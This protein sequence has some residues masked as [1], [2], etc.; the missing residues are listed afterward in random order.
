MLSN[1]GWWMVRAG[2]QA[3]RQGPCTA[4]VPPASC[5]SPPRTCRRSRTLTR[6]CAQPG[7]AIA[8]HLR[9]YH[10]RTLRRSGGA[11]ANLRGEK[12]D[13]RACRVVCRRWCERLTHEWFLHWR[14]NRKLLPQHEQRSLLRQLA[15]DSRPSATAILAAAR[16]SVLIEKESFASKPRTHR[17]YLPARGEIEVERHATGWEVRQRLQ[18]I[19]CC[20]S[21]LYTMDEEGYDEDGC[22]NVDHCKLLNA[23]G[24]ETPSAAASNGSRTRTGR[25]LGVAV[26]SA[27]RPGL[28]TNRMR[29]PV[30]KRGA[31]EIDCYGLG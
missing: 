19:V 31:R 8:T 21:A 17:F 26:H 7:R 22:K 13:L 16:L 9:R 27:Q 1:C 15:Q 20:N 18:I 4:S 14:E 10:E 25:E 12:E 3:Y 28:M 24:G 2:S 29:R 30:L 11:C 6:P 5:R 23:S